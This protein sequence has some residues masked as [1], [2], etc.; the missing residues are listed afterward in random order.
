[1]DGVRNVINVGQYFDAPADLKIRMGPTLSI[2]HYYPM[3]YDTY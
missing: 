3:D 2:S 1:M